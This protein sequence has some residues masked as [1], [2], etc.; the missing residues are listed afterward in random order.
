MGLG[1][2]AVSASRNKRIRLWALIIFGLWA[3]PAFTIGLRGEVIIPASAYA[4]VAARQ[5]YIPLR[6]WMGL[7]GIVVLAA[8]SAVR[9]IRQF[10]FGSGTV[11]VQAFNPLDGISELGYSIRPLTV[12][13]NFHEL[14][15][16]P[17][18][19]FATY[20]APFRR[21]IVG[22]ILGGEVPPAAEDMSVFST[23]VIRRVGTIGGSPAAEA[24]RAGGVLGIVGIMILLGLLVAHLDSVASSQLT[25]SAV[26]MLTFILLLWVRNDFTPVPIEVALASLVL[27]LMWLI[28]K[29]HRSASA[30]PLRG[31]DLK[32]WENHLLGSRAKP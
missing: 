2:P 22:R 6:P 4:V 30:V 16:E 28:D 31:D 12:V 8:G 27:L 19:G 29:S 23:M 10:G 13:I 14:L 5:R 17:F 24:Y 15:G 26:G 21:I 18:V 7:A 20:L 9:V 25:D 11:E 32:R 3:L 1:F